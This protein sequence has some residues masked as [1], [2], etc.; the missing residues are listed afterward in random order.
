MHQI[1]NRTI[2]AACTDRLCAVQRRGQRALR[3]PPEPPAAADT[4]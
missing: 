4:H 3:R 2:D 1:L